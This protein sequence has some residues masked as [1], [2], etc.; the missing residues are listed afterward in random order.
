MTT[1]SNIN[2][3]IDDYRSYIYG[4]KNLSL[5]TVNQ[6]CSQASLF[7]TYLA[8]KG[9]DAASFKEPIVHE[10]LSYLMDK[11]NYKPRSMALA[12]SI[13]KS[14]VKFQ[15]IEHIRTDDPTENIA[16]PKIGK[17]L[18]KVIAEPLIQ[19]ILNMANENEIREFCEKVMI[20][21]LYASGLRSSELLSLKFN[22]VN[23]ETK[24]I[25]VIGKG[26]KERVVP[27]APVAANMLERYIAKVRDLKLGFPNG[28]LF[29]D[30][31]KGRP[32]NRQQLY[33]AIRKY[34]SA[35]GLSKLPSAHTF[36]HA[37]ATHLLNNGADLHTVQILLG[38]TSMN[39]TEIYTHVATKHL[40]DVYNSKNPRA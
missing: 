13:I 32:L 22:N 20:L 18:P 9:I 29:Q 31:A 2:A 1:N 19:V 14:F 36:R 28:Y 30:Y 8:Q 7:L 24:L 21:I 10:Y 5:E 37:F 15:Q 25:R 6:Y 12:L 40:H 33:R 35:A 23:F 39:T 38:H 27:I 11:K 26:D 34:A 3:T 4:E 17:S 16:H